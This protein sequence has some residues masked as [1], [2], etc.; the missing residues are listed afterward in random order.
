MVV[1]KNEQ[2]VV[3]VLTE[4]SNAQNDNT[5]FGANISMNVAVL[6]RVVVIEYDVTWLSVYCMYRYRT[7][8]RGVL[9]LAVLR[10]SK[11]RTSTRHAVPL[12]CRR[13]SKIHDPRW[14]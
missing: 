9:T 12:Q 8:L 10:L 3:V 6:S 11:C 2:R 13:Q 1:V 4:A 7:V 14:T 5:N